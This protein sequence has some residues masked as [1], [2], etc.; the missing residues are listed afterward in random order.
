MNDQATQGTTPGASPA[1]APTG[2]CA[3]AR[4]EM[5]CRVCGCFSSAQIC[6]HCSTKP[7]D[8]KREFEAAKAAYERE[9]KKVWDL[10][11]AAKKYL[12]NDGSAGLFNARILEEARQELRAAIERG[13]SA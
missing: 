7:A 10:C 3:E 8:W 12:A 5:K 4:T 9:Y 6:W 11:E 13:L 2:G 1:L